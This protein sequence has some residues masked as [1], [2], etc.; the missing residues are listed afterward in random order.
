MIRIG[1]KREG[2][3][4]ADT[5]VALSPLQAKVFQEKH[6]NEVEIYVEKSANRCF[7][8]EEFAAAG[9]PPVDDLDHCDLILGIKETIIPRL[10]R[11]KTY[12]FFAHVIKKQAYN[13]EL[14]LT[15]LKRNIRLID[16]ETLLDEKGV[17]LI[18]FGKYAGIVGAHYALLMWGKKTGRFELR[19]AVECF[20]YEDM[21][22]E[23]SKLNM[24][25]PKILI[26][27]KGRVSSGIVEILNKAGIKQIN[28]D[29]YI[30]S[31]FNE[32][33]YVQLDADELYKHKEGKDFDF[34]HFFSHPADY[35]SVFER[36][37][38]HTDILING[39]FWDPAAD[40]FFEKKSAVAADFRIKIIADVS[41]DINGSVP[42]TYRSTTIDDPFYGVDRR[43]LREFEAF[44]SDS[45]DMMT[46]G[47]LPNELPRDATLMFGKLMS[48]TILPLYIEDREHT[49]LKRA[50]I[51]AD[52]RLTPRYAYLQDYVDGKK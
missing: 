24:G 47:N 43:T 15:V 20:D 25:N 4:P 14:L 9:F 17:R 49:I 35:L 29:A 1:L 50:T 46:I 19:R 11:D 48:E 16:Y 40:R 5:R 18:G 52:G 6:K 7:S 26:T 37:I 51:A 28:S 45:I 27:G 21:L 32:A 8:D 22:T 3:V 23:Y 12:M 39:I 13:R 33:V 41:C 10:M 36:F 30:N 38:P 44:G 2:K 34:Q 31:E 42:L